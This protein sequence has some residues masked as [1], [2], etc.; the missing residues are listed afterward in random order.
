M[1][2]VQKGLKTYPKGNQEGF[3]VGW[4][5]TAKGSWS[6]HWPSLHVPIFCHWILLF[7]STRGS[8]DSL[9]FL[10]WRSCLVLLHWVQ[11]RWWVLLPAWLIPRLTTGGIW[12]RPQRK[13][14][15]TAWRVMLSLRTLCCCVT[16]CWQQLRRADTTGQQTRTRTRSRTCPSEAGPEA[17]YASLSHQQWSLSPS[18]C[19]ETPP[20]RIIGL[21]H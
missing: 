17:Y 12:V 7:S 14:M 13:E 20:L 4:K 11:Q 10:C 19:G 18:T 2:S 8:S 1:L 21:W 15:R 16:G 6:L 5:N 9:S 3:L